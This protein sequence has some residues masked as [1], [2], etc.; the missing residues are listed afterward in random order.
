MHPRII[1]GVFIAVFCAP[2]L[3]S[4]VPDTGEAER[5]AHLAKARGL[6][7]DFRKTVDIDEDRGGEIYDEFIKMPEFI[8]LG[9]LKYLEAEWAT[10]K[11]SYRSLMFGATSGLSG[12]ASSGAR[13]LTPKQKQAVRTHRETLLRIRCLGDENKM[14]K[15][16]QSEGFPALQDLLRLLGGQ[17]KD[18]YRPG[19]DGDASGPSLSEAQREAALRIGRYRYDLRKHLKKAPP[20]APEEELGIAKQAPGAP[21]DAS[22]EPEIAASSSDRK[23]LRSNAKL[24]SQ[25]KSDEAEGI[26]QLNEWRIAMG[27]NALEIDPKLCEAARDHC[28]DMAEKGFFSHDSP[29]KGK[30]TPWARAKNFGT[31]AHAENIAINGSATVAN[32]SWFHSP[33]HHKNMF[34]KHTHVGLGRDGKHF[35]QLFR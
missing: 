16:L 25:L 29:V 31:T 4:E 23:V 11:R 30:S 27:L 18:A 19:P 2:L 1:L 13:A 5:A 33:G 20:S 26:R 34:G 10:R 12:S 7:G 14:K 15:E 24:K 35:T 6:L 21:A 8:Q 28:K 9:F 32:L 22:G 17:M 3:R